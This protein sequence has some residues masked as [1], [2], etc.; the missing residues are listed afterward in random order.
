MKIPVFYYVGDILYLNIAKG[1]LSFQK[2]KVHAFPWKY[3]E[4][5]EGCLYCYSKSINS[6]T[7]LDKVAI[8]SANE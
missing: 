1:G 2:V 5:V 4:D 8:G 3:E 7:H 6:N